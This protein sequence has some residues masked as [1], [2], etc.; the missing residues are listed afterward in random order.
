LVNKNCVPQTG[1]AGAA[2]IRIL[3]LLDP[4]PGA[5]SSFPLPPGTGMKMM[6]LRQLPTLYRMLK[7]KLFKD[8]KGKK[9]QFTVPVFT[10]GKTVQSVSFADTDRRGI[11]VNVLPWRW[12]RGYKG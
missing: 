6:R 2:R 9:Q 8:Y 12:R 5:A 4:V 3:A 1:G 10:A 7:E 11:W